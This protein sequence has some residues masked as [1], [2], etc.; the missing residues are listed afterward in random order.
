M[1][2]DP[3]PRM[4]E[5]YRAAWDTALADPAALDRVTSFFHL[6]CLVIGADGAT[7]FFQSLEDIK[8]FNA[9]RLDELRAGGVASVAVRNANT[10]S[11]GPATALAIVD[12]ELLHADGSQERAWRH[13]YTVRLAPPPS[14][15]VSAFQAG[16]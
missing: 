11:H 1:T 15:L 7:R 12:W 3:V 2:A 8:A 5:D 13:Y 9:A 4:I 10:V 16:S 14:I 6:P